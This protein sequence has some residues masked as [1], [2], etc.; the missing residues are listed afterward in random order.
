MFGGNAAWNDPFSRY[1][2]Y[3]DIDAVFAAS[4]ESGV[5]DPA[6]RLVADTLFDAEF[7]MGGR[8]LVGNRSKIEAFVEGVYG[9]DTPDITVVLVNTQTFGGS[10]DYFAV[11]SGDN[12]SSL[13]TLLHELGHTY[14]H[15]DDEYVEAGLTGFFALQ[16][17]ANSVN[18]TA[19]PVNLPWQ[20]WVGFEDDLGTVGRY[21]GGYYRSKDIW[22]ATMDSRMGNL[23]LAFNAPQ[24][25]QFVLNFYRD[26]GD[27]LGLTRPIAGIVAALAPAPANLA[28]DW[29]ID[30]VQEGTG[31]SPYFDLVH[32]MNQDKAGKLTLTAVD[33]TGLV[34]KNLDLTRDSASID[35]AADQVS[36][37]SD[38]AAYTVT[39]DQLVY[40]FGSGSHVI[41]LGTAA[42][43]VYLDGTA[44]KETLKVAHDFR[45]FDL[46]ALDNGSMVA[47]RAGKPLFALNAIET[48][49]FNDATVWLDRAA[50]RLDG[51]AGTDVLWRSG[52]AR[53]Y[54]LAYSEATQ[55]WT[56]LDTV[57]NRDASIDINNIELVRF[58]DV[59]MRLDAAA[60]S[61]PR[62]TVAASASD[63][64][65]GAS[66]SFIVMA[67]NVAAGQ[68]IYY[69]IAGVD[70]A[71]LVGRALSGTAMVG[72]GGTA[73]ID[74]QLQND[75]LSEGDNTLTLSVSGGAALSS[76]SVVVHD[77]ASVAP[78]ASA[79]AADDV[80]TGGAGVE[81]I[82]YPAPRGDFVV[83]RIG[84][85]LRVDSTAF[86]SD[87][88]RGIERID[89]SDATVAFDVD[90]I[91]GQAYRVYQAAFNR[92][93]DAK[94][95]GFWIAMMDQGMTLAAVAKGFT[96]SAE[97][98]SLY[99]S[100]PASRSLVEKFYLNTL[101]RTGDA[102]GIAFWVNVLDT[103]ASTVADV[104]VGFSE[105]LEN[106]AAL[107]GLIGQG[108]VFD[109]YV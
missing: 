8:V 105:S 5:D 79:P 22:R 67:T 17:I 60:P 14:A 95:L 106:Q 29:N 15:L 104:L 101:G 2:S 12:P 24:K 92:T 11:V 63:V 74:V 70:A 6:N 57:A 46:I 36:M 31:R 94:G 50:T 30:G 9:K 33:G 100:A 42:S 107:I 68:A 37:S 27:Y 43:G 81:T 26:M 32:A 58:A 102:A 48:L 19:D 45:L 80:Y 61:A 59:T 91:A 56:V 13:G 76:A 7:S 98:V 64:H 86:N 82:H 99:G 85:D 49:V 71:D 28:F 109:S 78:G 72:A 62:Y 35:V 52:L 21:E 84:N 55:R 47:E 4:R 39:N 38:S 69:T 10:A 77:P 53:D 87:T 16:Y 65:E 90:G 23:Q 41:T 88:L 25:E 83:K 73:R 18:V 51:G 1:K 108:I 54:R 34:R 97:F 40:R 20:H 44:G 75:A 3:F 66:G 96:E 93:P 89:F 103:R